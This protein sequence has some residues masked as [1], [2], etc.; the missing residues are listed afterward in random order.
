[1]SRLGVDEDSVRKV[2]WCMV[3]G[4]EYQP[5]GTGSWDCYVGFEPGE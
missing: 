5:V 3:Q 4:I 1:M 2:V